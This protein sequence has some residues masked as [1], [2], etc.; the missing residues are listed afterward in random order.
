MTPR[1]EASYDSLLRQASDT[2][3]IYLSEAVVLAEEYEIEHNA[4]NIIRIAEMIQRDFNQS[5]QTCGRQ[6]IAEAIEA[7]K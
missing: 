3:G 5:S 7:S 1:I 2:V 4:E 6:L